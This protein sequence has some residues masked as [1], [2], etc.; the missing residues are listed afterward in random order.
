MIVTAGTFT[1]F[2]ISADQHCIGEL[3]E[4]TMT[5]TLNQV[6]NANYIQLHLQLAQY[7][8]AG[9]ILDPSTPTVPRFYARF[10]NTFTANNYLPMT[11]T[12]TDNNRHLRAE[13]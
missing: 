5:F 11:W 8:Q 1:P 7:I 3:Q 6:V 12:D 10:N 9:S 4:M 2:A 13:W